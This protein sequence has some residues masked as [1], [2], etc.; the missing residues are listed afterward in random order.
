M[1]TMMIAL[2]AAA[3]LLLPSHCRRCSAR[4]QDPARGPCPGAR[5]LSEIPRDRRKALLVRARQ[6][7]EA[8][9]GEVAAQSLRRPGA[10]A[11]AAGP[12]G[13]RGAAMPPPTPPVRG[14]EMLSLTE[15]FDNAFAPFTWA[16]SP[17]VRGVLR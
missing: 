3:A 4:L 7:C 1:R 2:A 9:A 12:A 6:G 11:G 5:R 17:I 14:L 8:Q 16:P 13:C 15:R 10:G